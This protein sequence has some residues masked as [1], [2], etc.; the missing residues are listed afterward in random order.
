MRAIILLGLM[1]FADGPAR[2]SVSDQAGCFD[3]A[4]VGQVN[5]QTFL[6]VPAS[7]SQHISMDAVYLW[8]VGVRHVVIGREAPPQLKVAVSSHT[9]PHR[10]A[11]RRIVLFIKRVAG[12]QNLLIH[13]RALR[14]EPR[15]SLM[16]QVTARAEEA[17]LV[18][19]PVGS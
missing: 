3:W 6:G 19:C 5:R 11:T 4:I 12:D 15:T 8:E 1:L 14:S 10:H 18:R 7:D 2:A 16:D 13:W 9:A 17:G